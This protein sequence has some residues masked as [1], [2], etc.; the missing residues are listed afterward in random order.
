MLP[1][2]LRGETF[3]ALGKSSE[4]LV[5]FRKIASSPGLV[6][7]CWSGPLAELELARAQAQSGAKLQAK[8][9]YEK[10]LH[11]WAEADPD[12]PLVKQAHSELS[13]LP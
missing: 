6:G 11:L 5:E 13:K 8:S 1:V 3:L 7:N 9:S 10:L 4:A 2:L 12:V